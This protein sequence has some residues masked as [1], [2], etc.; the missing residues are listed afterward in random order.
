MNGVQIF[1]SLLSVIGVQ[2]VF[3][4]TIRAMGR[5]RFYAKQQVD[6][7][8]QILDEVRNRAS[9]EGRNEFEI[10]S[11]AEHTWCETP[12]DK[13]PHRA[14]QL[15]RQTAIRMALCVTDTGA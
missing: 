3:L 14:G 15:R 6:L 2:V 4:S 9:T 1:W 13:A 12:Y 5:I 8:R 10:S 7:L 11:G